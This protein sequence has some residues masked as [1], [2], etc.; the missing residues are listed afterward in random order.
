VDD[1]LVLT[2][3]DNGPGLRSVPVSSGGVGL[4]NT[5]GRLAALYGETGRLDV[6]NAPGGGVSAAVRLPYH[7]IGGEIRG[8]A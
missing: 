6:V 3:L 7:E 5:R 1:Q 8:N 2:V 4:A